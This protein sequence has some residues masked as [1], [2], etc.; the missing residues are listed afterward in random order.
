MDE[1]AT[2]EAADWGASRKGV[3]TFEGIVLFLFGVAFASVY[4]EEYNETISSYSKPLDLRE[5]LNQNIE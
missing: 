5:H 2:T 1:R 3:L 4:K